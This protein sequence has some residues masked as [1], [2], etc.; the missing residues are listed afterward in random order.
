MDLLERRR[1]IR[2]EKRKKQDEIDK[3]FFD[4]LMEENKIREAKKKRRQL[5]WMKRKED[6]K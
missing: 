1:T 2:E 4:N 5:E 6:K 3:E